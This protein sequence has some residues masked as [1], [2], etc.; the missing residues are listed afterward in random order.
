[1]N[2]PPPYSKKK[3]DTLRDLLEQRFALGHGMLLGT[4]AVT[5]RKAHLEPREQPGLIHVLMEKDAG[6]TYLEHTENDKFVHIDVFHQPAEINISDVAGRLR[7]VVFRFLQAITPDFRNL[8]E[9]DEL[10][11]LSMARQIHLVTGA[12]E[13]TVLEPLLQVYPPPARRN[14]HVHIL[15]KLAPKHYSLVPCIIEETQKSLVFQGAKLRP[16]RQIIHIH[17]K[18]TKVNYGSNNPQL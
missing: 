7:S 5:S 16:V 15:A 6:E 10:A 14:S 11:A 8:H 3:L 2:R 13:G 1:M 12:G 9:E 18:K 17:A 4:F